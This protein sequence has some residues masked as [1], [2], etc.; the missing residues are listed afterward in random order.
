MLSTLC[1]WFSCCPCSI[2]VRGLPLFVERSLCVVCQMCMVLYVVPTMRGIL[3]MS[4]EHTPYVCGSSDVRGHHLR[5]P[6][7]VDGLKKQSHDLQ[8]HD[9]RH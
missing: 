3:D 5:V 1:P 2:D 9:S 6:H 7:D 8:F 4:I